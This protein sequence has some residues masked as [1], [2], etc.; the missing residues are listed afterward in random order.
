MYDKRIVR[1]VLALGLIVSPVLA[2]GA[3]SPDGLRNEVVRHVLAPCFIRA[4]DA[5]ENG[6]FSKDQFIEL[7][8]AYLYTQKTAN[9][10][11]KALVKTARSLPT[12]KARMSFYSMSQESCESTAKK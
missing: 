3:P 2:F 6:K 8:G 7:V 12:E 4:Y 5:D 1:V 9:A 10:V 11:I